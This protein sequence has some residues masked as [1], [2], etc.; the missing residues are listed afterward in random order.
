[1]APFHPLRHDARAFTARAGAAFVVF[2]TIAFVLLAG[3]SDQPL[4]SAEANKGDTGAGDAAV[5]GQNEAPIA[6]A[7]APEPVL[8]AVPP[9]DAA[10]AEAPPVEA[11]PAEV[12]PVEAPPEHAPPAEA[13]AGGGGPSLSGHVPDDDDEGSSGGGKGRGGDDDDDDGGSRGPADRSSLVGFGDEAA[14]EAFCNSPNLPRFGPWDVE[15]DI[16][17][18]P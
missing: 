10:P 11:P 14:N 16:R 3:G 4:A 17:V 18:R 15:G 13:P 1:M 9:E 2:L 5:L 7:P 12:P 6:E 8:G